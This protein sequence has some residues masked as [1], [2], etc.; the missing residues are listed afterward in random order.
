MKTVY[1][2]KGLPASGKSTWSRNKLKETPNS[3]KRI[4]KDDLR[5]MLDDNYW[6]KGNEKFVLKI[7]DLMI[8]EALAAGKHVISDDTNLAPRHETRIRQLVKEYCKKTGE[9]V[10]VEVI[11]FDVP[12]EE[13]IRRD[14]KRT[15]S[16]GE[17][18]IRSMYKNFFAPTPTPPQ[19]LQQDNALLSQN[20][21]IDNTENQSI[22]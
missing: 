19:T 7:R 16:V 11:F 21:K 14:L 4:N 10:K 9:N 22:K 17:Q 8:K 15:H 1:I 3:Y 2:L 20:L 12:I 6:S 18:V 5:A 13:C